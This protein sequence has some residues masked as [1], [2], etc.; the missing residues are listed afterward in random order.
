MKLIRKI[1]FS[2]KNTLGLDKLLATIK[3][4]AY[5]GI[6]SYDVFLKNSGTKHV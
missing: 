6:I 3:I 4:R 1:I 2:P 5:P